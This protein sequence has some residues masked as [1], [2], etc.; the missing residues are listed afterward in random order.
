MNNIFRYTKKLTNMC[1]WIGAI[2]L[3]LSVIMIIAEIVLRRFFSSSLYITD[4]Y[5][6]YLLCAV[7]TMGM[8]FTLREKG[9]IR[10][11]IFYTFLS[12][13]RKE[14]FDKIVCLVGFLFFVYLTFATGNLFLRS[15]LGGVR[16]MSVSQTYIAIPQ[17]FMPLGFLALAMQFLEDFFISSP[18]KNA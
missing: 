3:C 17:F 16:A 7:A 5:T 6:G 13:K 2:M 18:T 15:L 12:P 9:H 1:F 8:A 14:C 11:T 4:E 10:M